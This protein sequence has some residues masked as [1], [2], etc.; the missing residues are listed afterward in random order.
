MALQQHYKISSSNDVQKLQLEAVLALAEF[1]HGLSVCGCKCSVCFWRCVL[2]NDHCFDHSCISNHVCV[3]KCTYCSLEL[4][5]ENEVEECRN[6]AGH[7][8]NHNCK[9]EKSYMYGDMF[10]L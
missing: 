2:E 6:L 4:D 1:K 7:D 3:E 10:F 9:K 8:G 5:Q